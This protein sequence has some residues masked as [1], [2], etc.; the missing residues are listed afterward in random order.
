[1]AT[2]DSRDKAAKLARRILKLPEDPGPVISTLD[3]IRSYFNFSIVSV[4]RAFTLH[5]SL[6][7]QFSFVSI[8]DRIR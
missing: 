5:L 8:D 4:V 2:E 1:M 7:T 3:W 6:T